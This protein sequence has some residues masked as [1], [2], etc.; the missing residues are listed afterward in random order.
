MDYPPRETIDMIIVVGLCGGNFKATER[1]YARIYSDRRHPC[2]KTIKR[3]LQRAEMGPLK[4]ER[5]KISADN[6]A[7]VVTLAEVLQNP[8]TSSRQIERRHGGS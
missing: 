6:V 7:T 5:K 3:L 1:E 8:H 4:R 2:R